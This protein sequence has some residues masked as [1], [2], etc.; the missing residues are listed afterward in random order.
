MGENEA[1]VLERV[2]S[3]TGSELILFFVILAV[4]LL[5]LYVFML[6]DR[7]HKSESELKRQE[8]YMDREKQIIEV[9][10]ENSK[11]NAGLKTL[12]ENFGEK[13]EKSL[14]RVHLRIDDTNK[15]NIQL[16]EVLARVS[17]LIDGTMKDQSVIKD[18]VKNILL[19]VSKNERNQVL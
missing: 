14:D 11:V 5:P 15:I 13:T 2:V 12:L 4:C 16:S 8:N 17:T 3:S 1:R 7:K 6:K 18:D 9:I 19:I 10:S